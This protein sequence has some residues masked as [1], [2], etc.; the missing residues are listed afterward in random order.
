VACA[1]SGESDEDSDNG[2]E[3]VKASEVKEEGL[4]AI[5]EQ[6][7]A[8]KRQDRMLK[9]FG[10]YADGESL[11]D[12][13]ASTGIAKGTVS[14]DLNRVQAMIGKTFLPG[15]KGSVRVKMQ[16]ATQVKRGKGQRAA[17]VR[18][19][20]ALRATFVTLA[21]SAGVPMELVRRVTGHATVEVVVK[22]YF[23]PGR[24]EFKAALIGAMPEVLT[25]KAT[26]SQDKGCGIKDKGEE[27][28]EI[29]AK[30]AAG[31]ATNKEKV[32]LKELA[33]GVA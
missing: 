10:R 13:H 14:L 6:V 31:T 32:R 21:L 29:A 28:V 12:I 7:T 18:D 3:R 11:R 17:S 30:V 8:G 25:G 2:E 24:E 23:R 15:N 5:R 19:W 22:H 4:A 27:L 20:H 26:A 33:A 1:L 16:E 9:V